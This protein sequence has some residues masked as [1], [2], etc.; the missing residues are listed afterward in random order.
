MEGSRLG[1]T[2][3]KVEAIFFLKKISEPGTNKQAARVG[4][5][6]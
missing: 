3:I 6:M 2:G 1:G 5:D 4:G